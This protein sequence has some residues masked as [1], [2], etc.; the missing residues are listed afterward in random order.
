MIY[1]DRRMNHRN[2]WQEFLRVQTDKILLCALFLIMHYWHVSGEMQAAV[3][4][5]LIGVIQ[6]QRFSREDKRGSPDIKDERN[7]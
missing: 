5:G 6:S 2:F 1:D 4:G 3:M 7:L